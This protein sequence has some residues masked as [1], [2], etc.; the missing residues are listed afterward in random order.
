LEANKPATADGDQEDQDFQSL[1]TCISQ[2]SGVALSSFK[3]GYVKRRI[4]VR[5]RA[6]ATTTF[7]EY[8]AALERDREELPR[9]MERLTI[10]VTRFY[11]DAEVFH[12]LG[13]YLAQRYKKH[14]PLALWCAGCASGEEPYSMAMLLIQQGWPPTQFQI[15]ATDLDAASLEK[16]ERG[17]YKPEALLELPATFRNRF[18][19]Q[20]G[21]GYRIAD[22]LRPAIRFEEKNLFQPGPTAQFEVILCRNVLIYF[23]ADQQLHILR[24]FYE[25]LRP[26]GTLV[27]GKTEAL[28]GAARNW[29]ELEDLPHRI[30]RK[31]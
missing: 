1:I 31:S 28:F 19:C 18:F 5:M 12:R 7:K 23:T 27:L 13:E 25:A 8:Q 3:S 16:A 14:A 6:T 9:L 4:A 24:G 20:D 30:Y 21:R 29:F 17:W 11:R 2:S 10:H 26:E 15:I 22:F